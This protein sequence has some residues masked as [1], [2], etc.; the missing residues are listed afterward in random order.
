MPIS[1]KHGAKTASL[2]LPPT[3]GALRSE[4]RALLPFYEATRRDDLWRQ[5]KRTRPQ[6]ET[7]SP[8]DMEDTTADGDAGETGYMDE[9]D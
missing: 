3:L 1:V 8:V 4:V 6:S 7:E 9:L 2:P 5:P